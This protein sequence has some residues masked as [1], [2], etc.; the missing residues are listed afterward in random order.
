[1]FFNSFDECED[2]FRQSR[3]GVTM[4]LAEPMADRRLQEYFPP[5]FGVG[6]QL[7]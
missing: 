7:G 4:P 5:D 1:M 3:G 6:I 2:A